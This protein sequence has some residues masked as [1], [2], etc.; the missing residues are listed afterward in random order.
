[1]ENNMTS[2]VKIKSGTPSVC[3]CVCYLLID[4]YKCHKNIS[5]RQNFPLIVL[6]NRIKWKKKVTRCLSC[7]FLTKIVF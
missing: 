7:Q 1:M 2:Q 5:V 6:M 3:V 4:Y